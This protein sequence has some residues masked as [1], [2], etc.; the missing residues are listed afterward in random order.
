MLT[1]EW[2]IFLSRVGDKDAIVT[3][4]AIHDT[5]VTRDITHDEVNVSYDATVNRDY[6]LTLEINVQFDTV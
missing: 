1:I 3:L 5:I 6:A 4:D 2:N